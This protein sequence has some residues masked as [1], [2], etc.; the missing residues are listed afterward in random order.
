MFRKGTILCFRK[1]LVSEDFMQ[2]RGITILCGIFL[3]HSTEKISDG[4]ILFQKISGL[5]KLHK[6]VYQDFVENWFPHSIEKIRK[7]T[8]H[9]SEN[10]SYRNFF[11]KGRGY[12]DFLWKVFLSHSTEKSRRGT[13]LFQKISGSEKNSTRWCI[14]NLSKVV[15][16]TVQK[17]SVGG[18]SVSEKNSGIGNFEG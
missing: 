6:M 5:E 11:W 10:S 3:S 9:F 15:F 8:L 16:L 17:I 14:T 12:H 1:F 18:L 13:L 4:T 2:K 7:G